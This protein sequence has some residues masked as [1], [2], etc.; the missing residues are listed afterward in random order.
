MRHEYRREGAPVPRYAP[1]VNPLRFNL[2]LQINKSSKF[3]PVFLT[4]RQ[5]LP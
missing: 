1:L 4:S 3:R 5:K 2:L